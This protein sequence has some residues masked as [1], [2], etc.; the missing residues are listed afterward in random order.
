ME[1]KPIAHIVTDLATKFGVPRQSGVCN[2]RGRIVFEKEYRENNIK[3]LGEVKA[4]LS[5]KISSKEAA[6][7]ILKDLT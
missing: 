3:E 6:K 4:M 2:L 1:I 5:D 7:E